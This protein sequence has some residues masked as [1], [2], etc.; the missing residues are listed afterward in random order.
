MARKTYNDEFR[1]PPP[2]W[3]AIR[4]TAS[5]RPPTAR[6]STWAPSSPGSEPTPRPSC[7]WPPTLPPSN[8]TART[9][10]SA[11]RTAGSSWSARF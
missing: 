5:K 3:S 6:A 8:S 1:S 10:A 9:S 7:P 2:S 4:A 11:R